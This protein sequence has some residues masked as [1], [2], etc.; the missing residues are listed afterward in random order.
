MSNTCDLYNIHVLYI[1]MTTFYYLTVSIFRSHVL[2]LSNQKLF[3]NTEIY[4]IFQINQKI[5][6]LKKLGF[7]LFAS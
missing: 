2:N 3:S 7:L 1:I 5:S 4:E 6:H